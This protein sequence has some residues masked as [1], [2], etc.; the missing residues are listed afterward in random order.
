MAVFETAAIAVPTGAGLLPNTELFETCT[1]GCGIESFAGN[2]LF[3]ACTVRSGV[4]SLTGAGLRTAEASDFGTLATEPAGGGP[5][6]L[7][8]MLTNPHLRTRAFPRTAGL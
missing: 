8:S 5:R 1:A 7:L 2:E 3:A 6:V 4:D